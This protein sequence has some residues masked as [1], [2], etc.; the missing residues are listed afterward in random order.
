MQLVTVQR[1]SPDLNPIENGW[2]YIK[3]IVQARLPQNLDELDRLTQ[4]AFKEIITP[5]YCKKLYD[6]TSTRLNLVIKKKVVRLKY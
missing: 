3:N 1:K 5:E 4:E 6:S 2:G